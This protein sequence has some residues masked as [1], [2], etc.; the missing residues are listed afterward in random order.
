MLIRWTPWHA[1]ASGRPATRRDHG[2]ASVDLLGRFAAP[3]RGP[4]F[5]IVLSASVALAELGALALILASAEPV[6]AFRAVF[7]LVG[8]AFAA[9]GVIAWHRRPDSRSGLLMIATGFGLLVEPLFA[10]LDPSPL[11]TVGDLFEDAWSI[12]IIACS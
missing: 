1:V 5:W 6:P 11:R 12:P 2:G 10:Q 8:G 7:R 9:C 4:A 3:A